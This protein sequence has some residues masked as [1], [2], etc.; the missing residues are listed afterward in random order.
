MYLREKWCSGH[1][2]HEDAPFK[3]KVLLGHGSQEK[4]PGAG[5]NQPGRHGKHSEVYATPRGSETFYTQI[6]CG[7]RMQTEWLRSG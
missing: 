2:V 3:E 4:E 7:D 6:I 5:L 1:G